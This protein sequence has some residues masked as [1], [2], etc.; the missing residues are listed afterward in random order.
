MEID[1]FRDL[2]FVFSS[3]DNTSR[4]A[5]EAHYSSMTQMRPDLIIQLHIN[6]IEMQPCHSTVKMS[7]VL[8]GRLMG[9]LGFD[10]IDIGDRDFR[11]EFQKSLL[12]FLSREDF[13]FHMLL[14]LSD[15][16]AK[17]AKLYTQE[18]MWPNFF[19][20]I[21]SG[22]FENNSQVSAAF[23]NCLSQCVNSHTISPDENSEIIMQVLDGVFSSGSISPYQII[24]GLQLLYACSS[25]S[26]SKYSSYSIY[27]SRV[28][29]RMDSSEITHVMSDLCSFADENVIFFQSCLDDFFVFIVEFIRNEQMP[30][31][32]RNMAI[33]ILS[34][35]VYSFSDFLINS[36][37]SIISVL[38]STACEYS[39]NEVSLEYDFNDINVHVA[40]EDA[41]ED[42][43]SVFGG[44]SDFSMACFAAIQDMCNNSDSYVRRAGFMT[45]SRV[46]SNCSDFLSFGLSDTIMSLFTTG[47]SDNEDICRYASFVAFE[48]VLGALIPEYTDFN[49]RP[50]LP[51]LCE[52]IIQEKNIYVLASELKALKVFCSFYRVFV[53]S[54]IEDLTAILSSLLQ[55][56]SVDIQ[57]LVLSCVQVLALE[58]SDAFYPYS[59][60]V[61]SYMQEVLIGGTDVYD[62]R[63]F[64]TCLQTATFFENASDSLVFEGILNIILDYIIE[65]PIEFFS[66]YEHDSINIAIRQI[67]K[68]FPKKI[69]DRFDKVFSLFSR[70]LDCDLSVYEIPFTSSRVQISDVI[71]KSSRSENI[72][73]CYLKPQV[74]EVTQ[75]MLSLKFLLKRFSHLFYDIIDQVLRYIQKWISIDFDENLSVISTKCL[76]LILPLIDKNNEDQLENLKRIFLSVL[77]LLK[78]LNTPDELTQVLKSWKQIVVFFGQYFPYIHEIPAAAVGMV[79]LLII[80]SRERLIITK[81]TSDAIQDVRDDYIC[82]DAFEMKIVLLMR[83]LFR[84]YPDYVEQ[85]FL[86]RIAPL[87]P[88]STDSIVAR[89]SFKIWTDYYFFAPNV[90]PDFG[91]ILLT[92]CIHHTSSNDHVIACEAIQMIS[93]LLRTS[94]F[95][96]ERTI[97]AINAIL[98]AV[99]SISQDKIYNDRLSIPLLILIRLCYSLMDIGPLVCQLNSLLPLNRLE[100]SQVPAVSDAILMLLQGAHPVILSTKSMINL[101][102]TIIRVFENE[103]TTQQFKSQLRDCLSMLI[104]NDS[105]SEMM[106]S[107]LE[108][109]RPRDAAKIIQILQYV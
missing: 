22:C 81:Q 76:I 14:L 103:K 80:E 37:E 39:E 66:G 12:I 86:D 4:E 98:K 95:S 63:L 35:L 78:R 73:R 9:S 97:P 36:Y 52:S 109:M 101:S 32:S 108:E 42:I 85:F 55:E 54:Y 46:F 45:L 23:I 17:V 64:F 83:Q 48:T 99:P 70:V 92:F 15:D 93:R 28:I 43:S 51:L 82:E 6:N 90:S 104:R 62:R 25:I 71:M 5:A 69:E 106:K 16:V 19:T 27:V 29:S 33:S 100:P 2:L 89:G 34:N 44:N 31:S 94:E 50:L 107:V 18:D 105:T 20:S 60:V 11:D 1:Q 47:F 74:H 58:A 24:T 57:V 68:I 72:I 88:L 59:S 102:L 30:P 21:F 96:L 3:E 61:L 40:A 65:A 77:S 67:S 53:R 49:G 91:N 7:I 38:V 84:H 79:E 26:S 87:F 10:I 41:L 56:M 13:D 8:L 75:S